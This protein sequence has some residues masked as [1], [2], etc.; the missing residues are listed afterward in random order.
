MTEKNRF[1]KLP[2]IKNLSIP[3]NTGNDAPFSP[4][5]KRFWFQFMEKFKIIAIAIL[6][7]KT[8]R[9]LAI[10]VPNNEDMQNG[11]QKIEGVL[12]NSKPKEQVVHP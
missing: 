9:V 1:K 11:L 12:T 8:P 2:S 5:Y 7:S 4:G 10:R 6:F 3:Q